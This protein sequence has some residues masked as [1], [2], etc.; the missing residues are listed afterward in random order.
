MKPTSYSN[1]NRLA[2]VMA[3]IQV[4]AQAEWAHRSEKGL[5]EQLQGTPKSAAT[6]TNLAESHR[7]FFRVRPPDAKKPEASLALISRHVLPEDDKGMRK[8]LSPEVTQKLLEIA[9]SL[10]DRE[11]TRKQRFITILTTIIPIGVAII[12]GLF[13]IAVALLQIAHPAP[14]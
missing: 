4:L 9:I 13:S 1:P 14:R 3:L 8:P 10:H 2:D 6:W 11:V 5:T 12:A 7:E